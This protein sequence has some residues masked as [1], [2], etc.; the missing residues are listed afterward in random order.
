MECNKL[1]LSD[2]VHTN[3]HTESRTCTRRC[4]FFFLACFFL[5]FLFALASLSAASGTPDAPSPLRSSCSASA[6]PA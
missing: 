3:T 5:A 1:M 2:P 6:A 4:Y